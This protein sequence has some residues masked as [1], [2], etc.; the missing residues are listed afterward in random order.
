M[1]DQVEATFRRRLAGP[2][3]QS[4]R[5]GEHRRMFDAAFAIVQVYYIVTAMWFYSAARSISHTPLD[6]ADL[7]L[8][9]PLA[10]MPAFSAEISTTILAN[11]YVIVGFLGVFLWRYLVVR[12]LI[13]VV[14]LQLTAWPN[15]FGAIHHGAHE[16]F[17]LSVCFLFLPSGAKEAM[18]DNRRQRTLFLYAFTI[19]PALILFFYT[20]SGFYK[21]Y[22]ATLAMALGG[23]GGFMPDAMAQTL[24]RRAL[25]TQS[26]P[27]WAEIIINTPILG[28]PL[29]LGLY[30]VELVAI[31]I[32]FRP[33]LHRIW[34]VILI[35]FHLGTLTFMDITFP[36]HILINGLLFVM[37]PFAPQVFNL[38]EALVAIPWF[39]RFFDRGPRR[40]ARHPL[41]AE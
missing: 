2:C 21:V 26:E 30:F 19:A 41:P 12:V 25:E 35:A 13:M 23:Y 16:W 15:S 9:W 1:I 24:A 10:W 29:Y 39:G 7:D 40:P 38:R 5:W 34:G 36:Q 32:L 31:A 27:L 14:L 22:Y 11:A 6:P 3:R 20:L 37:S 4:A 17:W 18:R 8:L 28:W 33:A